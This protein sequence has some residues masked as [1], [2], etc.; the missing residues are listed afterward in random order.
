MAKRPPTKAP[1]SSATPAGEITG[2]A[3]PGRARKPKTS[4]TIPP[5]VDSATDNPSTIASELPAPDR[6]L[7][8]T[9]DF[10]AVEAP[11]Q[12]DAIGPSEDEIREAAYHRFLERG[13]THGSELDDWL[14]AERILRRR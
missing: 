7:P 9:P 8:G 4:T 11:P 6:I 13:A 10:S 1:G 3:R 5:A 2:A 14:E 12:L